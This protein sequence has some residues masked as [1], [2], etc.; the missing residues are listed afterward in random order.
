MSSVQ[1]DP[2]TREAQYLGEN[3]IFLISLPRSGSTMLQRV[4]VGHSEIESSAEPWLMLPLVYSRREN[5]ITAEYGG[6]WA[7]LATDE[8]L[9]ITHWVRSMESAP[10]KAPFLEI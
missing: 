6:D 7:R 3:L 4:L 2:H 8:F 10:I 1:P 5:G 9:G